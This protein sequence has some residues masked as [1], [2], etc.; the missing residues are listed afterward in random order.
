MYR[1]RIGTQLRKRSCRHPKKKKTKR[2]KT[3]KKM[4]KRNMTTMAT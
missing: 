3:L 1:I 4:K 2:G